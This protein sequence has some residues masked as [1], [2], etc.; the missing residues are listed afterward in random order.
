[1][2]RMA[3]RA[4]GRE[5]LL[6]SCGSQRLSRLMGGNFEPRVACVKQPSGD[7]DILEMATGFIPSSLFTAAFSGH[8]RWVV[9]GCACTRVHV[10]VCACMRM[11]VCVSETVP[12]WHGTGRLC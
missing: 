12:H 6:C 10:C 5:S 2:V 8:C 7:T 3:E 4:V 1:M 9:W 11:S